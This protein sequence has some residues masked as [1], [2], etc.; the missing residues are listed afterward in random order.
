MRMMTYN[1]IPEG[2]VCIT[3]Y[4][5]FVYTYKVIVIEAYWQNTGRRLAEY[6]LNTS[7]YVVDMKQ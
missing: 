3:K 1:R 4:A 5:Y 6:W 2:W 7:I